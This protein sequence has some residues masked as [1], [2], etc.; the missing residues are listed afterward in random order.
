MTAYSAAPHNLLLLSRRQ[1]VIM[2]IM[3]VILWFLAAILLRS[4]APMG[5]YDGM[6]RIGLYLLIIPGTYPF[7]R[8][9]KKIARLGQGQIALGVSLATAT[10]TLLDGIALAWFPILYGTNI[11]HTAGAGGA[12]LWGA[13]VGIMLGF[14]M[15]KA[16]QT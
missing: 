5:I 8:L 7:L 11:D 16:G 10:A 6:G 3:G 1:A 12:I 9:L 13:G 14:W 15:D 2:V 4:L